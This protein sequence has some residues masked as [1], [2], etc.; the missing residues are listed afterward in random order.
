MYELQKR[1]GYKF[2]DENLL[3]RALTHSSYANEKRCESNER[4]EFLGDSVLSLLTSEFL[5]EHYRRLPEGE[6]TKLR[7]ALV[8]EKSLCGFSRQL[9]I[10]EDLLVGKGEDMAGARE[11]PSTLA[12]AFE[13]LLA[14][15]YLDGG[16]ESARNFV[17]PY[18]EKAAEA[19]EKGEVFKDY[20]TI[21]QEIVQ[22]TPGERLEYILT[23][24]EGPDH[25]KR[26]FSR[27]LLNSNVLG[28]GSGRTKKEAEQNAARAALEFMGVS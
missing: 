10:G 8:C 9:S 19:A 14:A 1:I 3:K 25:N 7:A 28:E 23:G 2:K 21:L 15:I 17:L 13:A 6:L 5:F 20:K 16:L 18:I 22:Q 12:D 11:R 26:F 27:V 4:L 24:E